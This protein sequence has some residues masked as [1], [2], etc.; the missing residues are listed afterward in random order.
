L[1]VECQKGFAQARTFATA[2]T[3]VMSE[4]RKLQAGRRTPNLGSYSTLV[5]YNRRSSD[6]RFS[7]YPMGTASAIRF[8]Q[9][10]RDDAGNSLHGMI[11]DHPAPCRHCL[12]DAQIGTAIL[13][14]SYHSEGRMV[15]IRHQAR[16]I[17]LHAEPCERLEQVDSLPEIVRHRL[18]SV[19]AYDPDDMCIYELGDVCDGTEVE[20]LLDRALADRRTDYVNINTARPGSFLCRVE[21]I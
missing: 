4:M 2:R 19:R 8:R 3:L 12:A 10:E 7:L 18:V 21:R 14:G 11:T 9:T 6:D 17:F 5:P 20:R 1:H 16:P 15:S 13:L